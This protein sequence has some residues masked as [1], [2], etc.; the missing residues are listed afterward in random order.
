MS[1]FSIARKVKVTAKEKVKKSR[2][3]RN[4]LLSYLLILVIPISLCIAAYGNAIA[5]IDKNASSYHLSMLAQAKESLELRIQE[6]R[7]IAMQIAD[8]GAVNNLMYAMEHD[9]GTPFQIWECQQKLQQY[10]GTNQYISQALITVQEGHEAI[11]TTYYHKDLSQGK[12]LSINGIGGYNAILSPLFEYSP[13]KMV[14]AQYK[15]DKVDE[16]RTLLYTKTFPNGVVD[17]AY[18]NICLVFDQTKLEGLLEFSNQWTGGYNAILDEN[19][20]VLVYSGNNPEEVSELWL[21]F[22]KK[23]DSYSTEHK[24]EKMSVTY[25]NS[26]ETGWTYL[27]VYPQKQVLADTIQVRN[28]VIIFVTAAIAVGILASVILSRR[29]TRPVQQIMKKLNGA[30]NMGDGPRA[31]TMNEYGIIQAALEGL[32]ERNHSLSEQTKDQKTIVREAMFR[33]LLN[34]QTPDLTLFKSMA[35]EVGIHLE[36]GCFIGIRFDFDA[37]VEDGI[38]TTAERPLTEYIRKILSIRFDKEGHAYYLADGETLA[39]L[40]F[41]GCGRLDVYTVIKE[42]ISEVESAVS[43]IEKSG[44]GDDVRLVIGISNTYTNPTDVYRC[45]EEARFSAEYSKLFEFGRPV[46]YDMVSGSV[47]LFKFTLSDHQHLLNI[48]KS[49][50]VEEAQKAFN[51]LIERN[52]VQNRMNAEMVEQLFYAIKGLLLEGADFAGDESIKGKIAASQLKTDDIFTTFL[53]LESTYILIASEIGKKRNKK[54]NLLV[55]TICDSLESEYSDANIT[56]TSTADRFGISEAYL[57]KLFREYAKNSF[58]SYLEELRISKA[59]EM[60]ASGRLK[61]AQ[62]AENTGYNSVES[63][64]RA[65]KRLTGI[66]PSEYKEHEKS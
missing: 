47:N 42:I 18:G 39:L 43:I 62:I 23:V 14:K 3:M 54:G 34:G 52:L 64:R 46:F 28:L 29:N 30:V 2:L 35:D 31:G 61:M 10:T 17:Y 66:A 13:G 6:A 38:S 45:A 5:T 51:E 22:N 40:Y 16:E 12:T 63:F 25:L 32:I 57:S 56:L 44:N 1:K 9:G 19:N 7:L 50:N 65:F 4:F 20:Q 8:D 36:E 26:E 33:V 60:L 37:A 21:S 27:S 59:K 49:G 58:A 53:S 55:N 24:G 15:D 41:S 11:S 48:V